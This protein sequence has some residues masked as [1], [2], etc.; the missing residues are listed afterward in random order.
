MPIPLIAA[1]ALPVIAAT[2]L[3]FLVGTLIVRALT[4]LAVSLV[5]FTATDAISTAILNHIISSSSGL[6]AGVLEAAQMIGFTTCVSIIASAYVGA[7]AIRQ[8]MGLYN[9]I[10]FG[11]S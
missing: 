2:A 4:A 10:A 5:T 11:R 6:P 9:R 1:A 7:I 3:R 8:A